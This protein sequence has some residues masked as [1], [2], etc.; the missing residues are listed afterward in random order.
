[1]TSSAVR[2]ALQTLVQQ[3]DV[4]I[5]KILKNLA[6][7][8]EIWLQVSFALELLE[9]TSGTATRA[10]KYP[11]GKISDFT[12]M[13]ERG[14]PIWVELKTQSNL[15][16]QTIAK[17]FLGDIDKISDLPKAFR[18]ENIVVAL[19]YAWPNGDAAAQTL[20]SIVKPGS[21][22]SVWQRLSGGW[23]QWAPGGSEMHTRVPTI[24]FYNAAAS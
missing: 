21:K 22:I 12:V 10:V 8:W 20:A 23:Q 11:N 2:M 1:M 9:Q 14:I 6:G 16:D 7:G 24:L 19:A 3:D 15:D 5:Q 13:P 4:V 17:R 18:D